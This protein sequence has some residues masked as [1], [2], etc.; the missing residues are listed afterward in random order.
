MAGTVQG[1]LPIG[2]GLREEV[3]DEPLHSRSTRPIGCYFGTSPDFPFCFTATIRI[4]VHDAQADI[5]TR[6]A[7]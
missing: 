7:S 4:R 2:R 5:T 6:P 3:A 1:Q